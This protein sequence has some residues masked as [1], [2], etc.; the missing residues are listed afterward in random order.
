MSILVISIFFVCIVRSSHC[1]LFSILFL[2]VLLSLFS[3]LSLSLSF[4]FFLFLF[5]FIFIYIY[6]FIFTFPTLPLYFT[7]TLPLLYLFIIRWREVIYNMNVLL[8]L[9][10][11]S[12]RPIHKDEIRRLNFFIMAQVQRFY[13]L[14]LYTYYYILSNHCLLNLFI[15]LIYES[16]LSV[17]YWVI[18]SFNYLFIYLFSHFLTFC[19]FGC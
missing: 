19:L 2:H 4:S 17:V 6:I 5:M 12:N 7:F 11:T 16:I 14:S 18:N 15:Y 8:D 3:F 13:S 10:S 9:R 1:L